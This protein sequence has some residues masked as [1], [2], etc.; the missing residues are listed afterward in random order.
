MET[1]LITTKNDHAFKAILLD[2]N[3]YHLL[4]SI[5]PD[6]IGEKVEIV[7]FLKKLN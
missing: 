3:D 4:E 7:Q 5:L 6:C 1:E 2:N